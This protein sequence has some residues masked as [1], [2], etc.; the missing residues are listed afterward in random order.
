MIYETAFGKNDIRGVYGEDI[1]EELFF[2]TGRGYLRFI[3]EKTGKKP[4]QIL[5]TVCHD[6]RLHSPALSEA[7]TKGLLSLG[8]R[9]INL[10]LAPTPIGYYSEAKGI[11]SVVTFNQD[12][13]GALII[14][15]SHNPSQYNGLKMTFEKQSLNEE[16]IKEVKTFTIKEYQNFPPK[17]LQNAPVDR[18]KLQEYDL[19]YDYIQDMSK[20]FGKIGE[21]LKVV[22]DSANATGGIVAPKL[23]RMLGCEVI[24]LYSNPDGRFPH[25]HPNPSDEKT[26]NDIKKSVIANNADLGI[27]FDGDS[28]RIGVI[29][30]DGQ[31]ISGDKLLL[32]YAEDYLNSISDK[33]SA[34]AIVSE[35][36]CSQVLFDTINQMGGTAIMCRTGH[37]YIKSKMKETGALLAG[38]MSGHVFFKDR[39]YGYDDAIYAG[40]RIIEIL[41][42]NKKQNPQFKLEDLLKPFS[43]V[44]TSKEYRINCPNDKKKAV[45]EKFQN[46]V[47]EHPMMFSD[48]ILNIVTID[49]MRII[50]D[51]GF[52]LV[53]QSNTEPVFTLRF[54][55]K[56][57][58]MC[59]V[60]IKAMVDKL[61]EL[62]K[63]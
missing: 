16:Q 57:Q 43:K 13:D 42:K 50:F 1:T 52:A 11:S 22:V 21:G 36:K 26:L 63:D 55:A 45:L 6:A 46:Y 38:E 61:N 27:A 4:E 18:S 7:L 25:H 56:T 10:G 49:G 30:S 23:Y 24:E 5:V 39:Y 35:V 51:G 20:R 8:A 14:T 31:A 15:A 44:F 47:E 32:I 59:E 19:I 12:I 60:Y 53:R 17:T 29:A 48:K 28:D 34:P 37:G 62:I 33:A 58:T 2:Y 3:S 9:V 54:E 41:A 40:C